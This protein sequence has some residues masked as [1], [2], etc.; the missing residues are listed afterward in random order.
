VY[1]ATAGEGEELAAPDALLGVERGEHNGFVVDGGGVAVDGGG[2]LGAE[3][4]V[5][6]VEV[7]RGDVVGA[8]RAGE[9]HAAFNAGDGVEALHCFSLAF[10]RKRD[11][12]GGGAAKVMR[13]GVRGVSKW[14]SDTNG[15]E[16]ETP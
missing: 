3:V 7:E 12:H 10:S 14:E 2:G 13:G 6:S 16:T 5:A 1:G 15:A 9:L 11:R 4:A 8:M